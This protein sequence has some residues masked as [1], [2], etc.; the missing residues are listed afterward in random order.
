MD[1]HYPKN[2]YCFCLDCRILSIKAQELADKLVSE[3]IDL[4]LYGKSE[5][6]EV[7]EHEYTYPGISV[8]IN[9]VLE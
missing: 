3:F 5:H 7:I 1:R 6:Y 9:P 8:L 4:I 2:R